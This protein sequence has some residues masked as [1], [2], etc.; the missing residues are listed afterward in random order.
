VKDGLLVALLLEHGVHF[1][2]LVRHHDFLSFMNLHG[3]T[4]ERFSE[5]HAQMV[6][7]TLGDCHNCCFVLCACTNFAST[8]L[9]LSYNRAVIRPI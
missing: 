1:M 8:V 5:D 7:Y 3:V 4:S 2:E 9:T 6:A